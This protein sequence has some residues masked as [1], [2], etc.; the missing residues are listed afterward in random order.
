MYAFVLAALYTQYTHHIISYY[1]NNIHLFILYLYTYI[2]MYRWLSIFINERL[3]LTKSLE[4]SLS[5]CIME[6]MFNDQFNISTLFLKDIKGT[7]ERG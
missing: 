1:T 3:F 2:Y 5:F 4:Y 6:Y 7:C